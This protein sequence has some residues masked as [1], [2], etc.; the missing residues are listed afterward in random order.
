M[1]NHRRAT[2]L[3]DD[4][5]RARNR[6][7]QKS[8]RERSNN[9]YARANRRA[10]QRSAEWLKANHPSVWYR[11][12]REELERV[13]ERPYKAQDRCHHDGEIVAIG[14]DVSCEMCGKILGSVGVDDSD[15]DLLGDILAQYD[16]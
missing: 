5:Q 4:E 3:T 12:M 16:T 8:R 15:R 14:I 7:Y 2:P 6:S 10:L 11:F 1:A 9:Q 13:E